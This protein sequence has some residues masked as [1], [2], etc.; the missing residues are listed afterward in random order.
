VRDIKAKKVILWLLALLILFLC[1]YV[2]SGF[3]GT[4]WEKKQQATNMQK[5][6]E[7]KYQNDFV[8]KSTSYNYLSETYQSY[9]YPQ[10]HSELLFMVEQDQEAKEGYS[11]TYPKVVWGTNL[12]NNIKAKIKK[13]FPN[14]DESTFKAERIVEK[15]E[16][17]GPH[18][19]TYKEINV[20]QLACSITVNI[21]TKWEQ[22]DPMRNEVKLNQL[23]QYLKSIHFPVL[24]EIRYFEKEMNK[25]D[26]VY[27][28]T[29]DGR[30]VDK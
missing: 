21:N 14:I 30:I 2:Y 1:F 19:P 6:L 22:L 3:Y 9:A 23:Q 15:G 25:N 5:Y 26:K 12:A 13:L 29:E 7:K 4:P 11:D 16:Y 8:I 17:F 20:S 28:L 24:V 18:I 27:F 10:Q